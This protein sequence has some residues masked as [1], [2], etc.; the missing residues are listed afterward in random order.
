MNLHERLHEQLV[1]SILDA[2]EASQLEMKCKIEALS[3][4]A[5]T[6]MRLHG[7]SKSQ[8]LMLVSMFYDALDESKENT[9]RLRMVAKE[10]V[11]L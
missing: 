3:V 1:G 4:T 6:V 11:L 2:M 8:A 5:V 9:P 7:M 10:G